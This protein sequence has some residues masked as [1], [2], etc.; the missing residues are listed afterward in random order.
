MS[1]ATMT[2]PRRDH[3]GPD[4]G[5]AGGRGRCRR[6]AGRLRPR[7]PDPEG[8]GRLRPPGAAEHRRSRGRSADVLR[9]RRAGVLRGRVGRLDRHDRWLLRHLRRDAAAG[10]GQ[11]IYGDRQRITAGA[12]RPNGTAVEVEGGYR[13][14]PVA[15]GQR[16]VPR[17]WFLGGAV[18]IRDGQ[19]VIGPTGMPMMRLFPADDTE[20]IDSLDQHGPAG[21]RQPRLRGRRRLRAGRALLLVHG[22]ARRA[23]P[24]LPDGADRHVRH[25]HQRGPAR[26][27]P[28]RGRRVR[29]A[30]PEQAAG[31]LPGRAGRQ[32]G[33]QHQAWAGEGA[34][35]VGPRLRPGTA[36]GAVGR[37][38][39]RPSPDDGRSGALWLAAAH[40]GQT[41]L[42]AIELLYGAA[43]ADAV[44][45]TSPLDR[46]CASARTAVQHI[47]TQEVNYEVAGRLTSGRV[48]ATMASH[49]TIDYRGEGVAWAGDSGLVKR[50][51]GRGSASRARGGVMATVERGPA[52]R[53]SGSRGVRPAGWSAW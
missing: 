36:G 7:S 14:R 17:D 5:A 23:R 42:E 53:G 4:R 13:C 25:V 15:A 8:R 12:F 2:D 31:A 11:E 40:A 52:R 45:A 29:G 21:H 16:S 38:R 47:C 10:R 1:T 35:R 44:Y 20:I 24:A 9:R 34:R 3:A 22:A 49:W 33:R 39:R 19:P 27:R 6:A 51:V 48:E 26:D 50:P 28:P 46:A 18:I 30:L 32:A 37:G 41:A 43:G